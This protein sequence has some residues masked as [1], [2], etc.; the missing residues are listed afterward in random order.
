MPASALRMDEGID[1]DSDAIAAVKTSGIIGD[2]YVSVALGGGDKTLHNGDTLR[3][4]QS[5]FVLEDAI[6]QLINNSAER[7]SSSSGGAN[8]S[9]G[10]NSGA[11]LNTGNGSCCDQKGK[12]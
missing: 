2:K 3:Q 10:S 1:V 11:S 7:R 6:G 9:N 8:S 12:K 4:T 5:A